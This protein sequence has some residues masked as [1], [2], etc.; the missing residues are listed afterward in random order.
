MILQALNELFERIKDEPEYQL[1]APGYSVQ[2]ITFRIVLNADGTLHDIED[3][4]ETSTETTKSGKATTKRKAC[5]TL[6]PGDS[7]PTGQGINPCYFWDN[8]A[9]LLGYKK[10]DKNTAAWPAELP[11]PTRMTS[12]SRHM[13]ASIGEAQYQRPRPSNSSSLGIAGRR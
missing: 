4:R 2:N 6:V 13:R 1:P 9:Y 10:P 8:T 12:S 7:K 5:Q 3:A 11:P